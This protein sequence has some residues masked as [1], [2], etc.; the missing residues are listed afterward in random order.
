MSKRRLALAA[1]VAVTAALTVP[2]AAQAAG[3]GP[4]ASRLHDDF[5]G[6]GY[7]DLAVAAPAATVGGKARAGYVAVL[8]GSKNG[9]TTTGRKVFTQ[10]TAGVPGSSETG[11][12]FGSALDT[13]DLDGDGY[14]DLVVGVGGEDT[15][16]GVDAGLVEVVWGGA[17]GLAGGT[18]VA[19]GKAY[20][21]LGAKGR[22]TVG[23]IGDDGSPDLV[24]VAN[25][26]DLRVLEGP[27]TRGGANG[28]EVLVPD[29]YDSR[30]LD[31]ATGDVNGDGRTDV[32]GAEND[33]D[34]FDARRVVYWLG[35]GTGLNPFTLVYDVDG[36][37]LQSGESLDVGDVNRDGYDD[38]VVGRAIDGYDSDLDTYLAKG[39]RV[40]WI[41][42]TADGPDGVKA[43]FLNQD[44]P[45]V[46]G[47]AE[48]GDRFGTDVQL[49]DVDGDGFLDV[50]TGVPGEDIGSVADAGAVVVLSGRADGLT[51]AGY[52]QVVTQETGNVPG[53]AEKGD[54]FGTAVHL[55]DANGDGLADA[56]VG[57]PGENANTGFVWSFRS[58]ASYVVEPGGVPLPAT[59]VAPNGTTAFGNTLLGTTATG[60][61][62]G[63]GFAY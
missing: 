21:Q 38:I 34:E 63:T 42:G 15:S 47:T 10:N 54:A 33:G 40:A 11:D 27:F 44:S 7:A 45:G 37:G 22:L 60:A 36:A 20:D 24:T 61:R 14:A 46:P 18:S 17:N 52:H 53:T 50:L 62:L 56:A 29:R 59:I 58:R 6:D 48:K 13:A 28:G 9:L 3:A 57:A 4:A 23:D 35:N 41:P 43:Q 25:Q 30:V 32:V 12:G 2:V 49:G 1:A 19:S 55:G 5:N 16:A 31:L 8:Y 39:G 51:G 26:H